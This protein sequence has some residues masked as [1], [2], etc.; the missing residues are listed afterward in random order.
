MAREAVVTVKPTR[1]EVC[2]VI[3]DVEEGPM[4]HEAKRKE[5]TIILKIGAWHG[6]ATAHQVQDSESTQPYFKF[7]YFS[8]WHTIDVSDLRCR[9]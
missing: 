4:S 5:I 8:C 3:V 9:T 2:V 7:G 6:G 1:V